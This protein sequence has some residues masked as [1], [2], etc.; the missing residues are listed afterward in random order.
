[1]SQAPGMRKMA[2]SNAGSNQ[3]SQTGCST[4]RLS[5]IKLT[6]LR[7]QKRMSKVTG[8]NSIIFILGTRSKYRRTWDLVRASH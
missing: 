2:R 4:S 3:V 6:G 5:V 8:A 7:T 1:M